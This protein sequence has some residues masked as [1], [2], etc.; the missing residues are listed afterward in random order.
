MM[1]L[2]SAGA[3]ASRTRTAVMRPVA[4]MES[5]TA[6]RREAVVGSR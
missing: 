4:S 2:A 5:A 1:Q 3:I 6:R